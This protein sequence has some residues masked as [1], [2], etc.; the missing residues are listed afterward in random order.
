MT[1]KFAPPVGDVE[2]KV[3]RVDQ[4][5]HYQPTG[6]I[7]HAHTYFDA[8]RKA[9]QLL[10]EPN[11]GDVKVEM[12]GGNEPPATDKNV[13]HTVVHYTVTFQVSYSSKDTLHKGQRDRIARDIENATNEALDSH[14][15]FRDKKQVDYTVAA[16]RGTVQPKLGRRP[17]NG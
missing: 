8:H 7:V 4:A 12:L 13:V 1:D 5:G 16:A 11:L 17:K 9:A 2:W 6:A 3:Y 10:G 14:P 15:Y